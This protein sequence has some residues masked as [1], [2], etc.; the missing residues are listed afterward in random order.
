MSLLHDANLSAS[1]DSEIHS[2]KRGNDSGNDCDVE[3]PSGFYGLQPD[4]E[5]EEDRGE[6]NVPNV[7]GGNQNDNAADRNEVDIRIGQSKKTE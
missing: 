2:C 5:D 7:G 6:E 1:R 3:F 4:D